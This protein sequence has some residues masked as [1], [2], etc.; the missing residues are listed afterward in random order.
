MDHIY[1]DL[2][3]EVLYKKGIGSRV[4]IYKRTTFERPNLI[5]SNQLEVE[6]FI[7]FLRKALK[8]MKNK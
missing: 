1:S 7:E 2:E 5:L 3:G 4:Y 8:V 6:K